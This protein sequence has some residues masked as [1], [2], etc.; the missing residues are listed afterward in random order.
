M[1]HPV[2]FGLRLPPQVSWAAGSSPLPRLVELAQAAEQSGFDSL[3]VS[4]GPTAAE[5][6]AGGG[7]EA[8]TFLGAL[9]TATATAHLGVLNSPAG[10]RPPSLLAKQITA[11]DVISGGR[12]VLGMSTG[13]GVG[14]GRYSRLEEA[15]TVCRAMF[16]HADSTVHGR[17]YRIDN[18]ANRPRPLQRGGPPLVA[19]GRPSRWLL[20]VALRVADAV[21]L[22]PPPPRLEVV[23]AAVSRQGRL[24]AHP[25]GSLGIS[26]SVAVDP[27]AWRFGGAAAV[28]QAVGSVLGAGAHG[29]VLDTA[30]DARPEAVAE[31]GRALVESFGPTV[32]RR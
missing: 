11:V 29:V 32:E 18:A 22:E 15:L 14:P 23:V 17:A 13:G 2:R 30:A 20:Q 8:V 5:G 19:T 12:A 16:E 26:V 31:V 9:A 21:H 25:R 3:L 4:D 28:V 24:T 6:G 10:W 1:S 7:L 27:G